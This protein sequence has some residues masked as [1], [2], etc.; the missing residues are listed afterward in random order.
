MSPLAEAL[1]NLLWA[2]LPLRNVLKP[3]ARA[4]FIASWSAGSKALCTG[5]FKVDETPLP[6][7][8]EAAI[9]LH[10]RCLDACAALGVRPHDLVPHFNGRAE[11]GF[12]CAGD[13]ADALTLLGAEAA[14]TAHALLAARGEKEGV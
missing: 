6:S 13:A 8:R 7:P 2:S 9:R 10:R 5:V 3:P 12:S 14:R 11:D 1:N 4:A